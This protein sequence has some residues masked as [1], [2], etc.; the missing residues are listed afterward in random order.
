[1]KSGKHSRL[2]K[3]M[4]LNRKVKDMQ[5][6]KTWKYLYPCVFFGYG[7]E[8][9]EKLR[10]IS[11]MGLI[12]QI[13]VGSEKSELGIPAIFL[14]LEGT[15]TSF[16]TILNNFRISPAYLDD[17]GVGEFDERFHIL[18]LRVPDEHAYNMFMESKYSK[19]YSEAEL[20]RLFRT[21]TGY[22]KP[23][24]VLA[25]TEQG[26]NNLLDIIGDEYSPA[27]VEEYDSCLDMS[28]EVFCE[29]MLQGLRKERA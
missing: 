18:A 25:K 29:E 6:S 19:M 4:W 13:F 17:Y 11:R 1:M 27:E 14:L 9:T 2:R 16:E 21:P 15:T 7:N 12:K 23:Y 10:S 5:Y 22:I 3:E 28:Q 24:E 20:D 8:L 26:L